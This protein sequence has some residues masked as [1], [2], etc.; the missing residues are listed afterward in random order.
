[1]EESNKGIHPMKII[2][3]DLSSPHPEFVEV[4]AQRQG[5]DHWLMLHTLFMDPFDE[6][7]TADVFSLA[8]EM[9]SPS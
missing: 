6:Y 9:L 4:L 3:T 5:P 7:F 2:I 8:R 1:M